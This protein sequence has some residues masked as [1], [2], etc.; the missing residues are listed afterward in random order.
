M[1]P[2]SLQRQ[3]TIEFAD[4]TEMS[5]SEQL[6]MEQAS[7]GP[8]GEDRDS[9]AGSVRQLEYD[10]EGLQRDPGTIEF[11]DIDDDSEP[12]PSPPPPPAA[13]R[14]SPEPP[15]PA[16]PQMQAREP[17]QRHEPTAPEDKEPDWF[18]DD[19][20]SRA[21]QYGISEQQLRSMFRDR[22]ELDRT[23]LIMDQQQLQRG[24]QYEQQIAQQRA[25]QQQAIQNWQAQQQQ[26]PPAPPQ[27]YPQTPV[28]QPVVN[29][30]QELEPYQFQHR[31]LWEENSEL[32]EDIE[33]M[34]Q[35]YQNMVQ[36]QASHLA[37]MQQQMAAQMQFMQH[38]EQQRVAEIQMREYQEFDSMISELG[39]NYAEVLGRG[40]TADMPQGSPQL[41][42]RQ[43]LWH[44]RRLIRD[45]HS[46][47]GR[48]I[49]NKAAFD[50][51]LRLVFQD[52]ERQRDREHW[53]GQLR[54]QQGRWTSR[55]TRRGRKGQSSRD[56]VLER[57]DRAYGM[58]P[59]A[60]ADL[61]TF[62]DGV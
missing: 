47:E 18:S 61:E 43:R 7:Q 28:Q 10:G 35:H 42:N 37:N 34:N 59:G 15:P 16:E 21:E 24:I 38:Q 54:D 30:V 5:L 1:M 32:R 2:S 33:G 46:R 40:S 29:Q 49:P 50:N 62:G 44:A 13:I 55:P 41:Q 17:V 20:R 12:G 26:A 57:W 3:S 23:L 53:Q 58:S 14:T 6:D 45:N 52:Q 9:Q 36:T 56:S 4:D 22:D 51:A 39:E 25:A 19:E 11:A 31:E 8:N 27:Q 48:Q 60:D